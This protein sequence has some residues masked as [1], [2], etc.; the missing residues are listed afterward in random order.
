MR[1]GAHWRKPLGEAQTYCRKLANRMSALIRAAENPQQA[2]QE[3]ADAATKG[4]L[5]DSPSV[6]RRT[7]SLIFSED[8]LLSNPLAPD[9]IAARMEQMPDPLKLADVSS[10]AEHLL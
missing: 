9:W 7:D 1:A 2:M 5:I 4:G 8:L 10:L 3:I 6:P